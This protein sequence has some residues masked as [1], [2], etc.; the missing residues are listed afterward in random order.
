V[1][2]EEALQVD[3]VAPL[4]DRRSGETLGHAGESHVDALDR[5]AGMLCQDLGKVVEMG[6]LVGDGDLAQPP[7][8][9][10]GARQDRQHGDGA[11]DRQRQALAAGQ[12]AV[13][14]VGNSHGA[15]DILPRTKV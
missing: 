12:A 3:G 8:A 6:P 4:L 9:G 7:R 14:P 1:I 11:D 5:A 2:A 10:A 15:A 13:D